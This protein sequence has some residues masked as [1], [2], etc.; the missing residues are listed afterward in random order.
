M[1][2]VHGSL[3]GVTEV[4]PEAHKHQIGQKEDEEQRRKMGQ[5]GR[6]IVTRTIW[7]EIV[8][9]RPYKHGDDGL[10]SAIGE[11]EAVLVRSRDRVRL[12]EG[13]EGRQRELFE[14]EERG[15]VARIQNAELRVLLDLDE[16]LQEGLFG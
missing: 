8:D 2:P 6:Q 9:L 11:E 3:V 10:R 14:I 12:V 13:G 16:D 4:D 15:Y 5:P 1:D 7:V